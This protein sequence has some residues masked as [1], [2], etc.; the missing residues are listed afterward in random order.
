MSKGSKKQYKEFTIN[1][2]SDA[3][4][5]LGTLISQ[6]SVHLDKYIEYAIEA[7]EL[8]KNTKSKL[9]PA[10]EYDNIKDKLL[11]RQHELLKYIAD[12]QSSSFSYMDF[13]DFLYRHKY[14]SNDLEHDV[15]ETLNELLDVRNWTFHNPQSMMVA[16]REVA[17][18]NI[19]KEYK[20]L[21]KILP[22]INPVIIPNVTSYELP[23]LVSLVEHN[24]RRI[25]HYTL[26][27]D[28]MKKD[29]QEL[30]DNLEPKP[31]VLS[32]G[33]SPLQVQYVERD[34][35]IGFS[36]YSSDTAQISMAIQ[37]SKYDGTDEKYKEWVIRPN[38]KDD[39]S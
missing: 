29:Y 7:I 15:K 21:V 5:V 2:I 35:V 8:L 39:K 22:Q 38:I 11:H 14:L 20:D 28:Q 32:Q 3:C 25:D 16:A 26:I 36:D 37:K 10:K 9:I 24:K 30:F 18:K 17:E 31:L 6:V 23:Y 4:I 12:R 13:R 1:S 34:T 19:P 27:L 33:K